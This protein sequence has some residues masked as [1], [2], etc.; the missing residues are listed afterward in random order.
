MKTRK[1][2]LSGLFIAMGIITPMI[3]HTFNLTGVI[4]LPMH[5][6]VIIGGFLLGPSYG[7]V[8]GFITPVISGFLTGMP[9]VMPTMPIMALELCGYAFATGFLYS[10]TN[11]IYTSLIGSMIFGRLCAVVGAFILS[12]SFAPQ[13][14]PLPYIISAVT[15]G[16]PG[17]AVQILVIPT[18]VKFMVTNKETSRVLGLN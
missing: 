17:I 12:V 16:L 4:F 8:V 7:A 18:L 6:P 2:I 3:F 10:K 1:I 13:I 5:L 11:K 14:S 15:N 9:P